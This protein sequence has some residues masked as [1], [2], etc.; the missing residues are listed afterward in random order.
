[1]E[2]D[3]NPTTG[4]YFLQV[5]RSEDELVSS[6][7]RDHGFD[8]SIPSSNG[9]Y[10]TL[11]TKE[12]YCAATFYDTATEAAKSSLGPLVAEIDKSWQLDSSIHVE[13][14]A[15]K[16]L[17][18]FQKAD[19]AYGRSRTNFLVGDQPGLGKT[20]IAICTANDMQAERVLV[21]CPASI[22][23]QWVSK[24]REWT[25]MRWPLI[26]HPILNARNGV[27]PRAQWTVMSYEM[28]RTP[29]IA[30]A[31]LKG[32]YDLLILDEAHYLKT[33]DARRT[34]AI[35]GG[36][37][38]EALASVCSRV[39]A[40]TG[41][42]LPNRP[43]EAYTM[44]RGLQFDSIDF[45][46]E[47]AFGERFN[48]IVRREV[49]RSDG[50]ITFITDERTG[51]HSEL[52]NRMRAGFMTRHLK[53]DVLTQLKL[54]VYDLVQVEES[55]SVKQALK[56][57]SMLGIDPENLAGADAAAI[58]QVAT[59]RRMM[60]IAMAP[61][62]C[63]YVDMLIEGGEEKIVLFGWHHEV[64]DIYEHKLGKHGIVRVDGN[65]TPGQ[66][67][68][69]IKRFIADP[70][71]QVITGNLLSLGTGTDGLQLVS[72]HA[73]IGEPSWTPGE[74]IQGFDRLDRFGQR[75]TVQGDIFVAPN[76]FAE[77]ILA[78]SL[79]KL[80]NIHKALD[81]KGF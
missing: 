26:I 77:R 42:P 21:I 7:M 68:K 40:L 15:D 61:Q 1:M 28:A 35:F 11:Y 25:T 66:K 3:F 54:P 65:T 43:R 37:D 30:M 24:I 64:L 48:P 46:S 79:R 36:G 73:L 75:G 47:R 81:R 80:Q 14:P 34:R 16:E 41:T 52:Q 27:H 50:S 23:L 10:S 58:G 22:R 70:E 51:R 69:I 4:A 62:V 8:L 12:P 45:M 5:P 9:V 76:S 33:P 49:E 53:R 6:L 18:G 17:W 2:L 74:N 44:A 38:V 71:V 39:L 20:P 67:D 60:G 57:E 32:H 59:V 29:A 19:I 56:A 31:L 55:G 63:D 72:T 78:S 13:A